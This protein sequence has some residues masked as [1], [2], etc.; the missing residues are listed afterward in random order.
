M[1]SYL[2]SIGFSNIKNRKEMEQLIQKVILNAAV[3]KKYHIDNNTTLAEISMEIADNIGITVFGEYDADDHFHVDHYFPFYKSK[4]ISISE[5]IF[6]NKKV[7]TDSYTIMCDDYRLGVSL[8]FYLQN[9][10][11]FIEKRKQMNP[12]FVCPI[13][14]SAL[15]LEGK[16]LLPVEKTE[17]QMR[18][19]KADV[20]H[21]SQLIAEA[22]KGNQEAI[23][24]LTIDD[25]DLYSSVT[26]R[27]QKEDIY[28]IVETSFYP[29]GSESDNYTIIGIIKGCSECVNNI[30][31]EEMHSLLIECNQICFE[32]CINKKDL[33]GEPLPGRRFKGNVWMQGS[34]E[35]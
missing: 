14:L 30:T 26:R 16:I 1:H 13:I 3:I 22:K 2:K 21:R 17:K 24:N 27:I 29:F 8:I 5:E 11:E 32:I 20:K 34:V 12:P 23:D 19:S 25:I 18:L 7:D 33:L 10:L 9:T 6:I 4:N 35:F 15:S 31:R 28:S